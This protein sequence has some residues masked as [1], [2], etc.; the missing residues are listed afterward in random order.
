MSMTAR[1]RLAHHSREAGSRPVISYRTMLKAGRA[2]RWLVWITI[3]AS[4][5]LGATYEARTSY[6]QAHLLASFDKGVRFWTAPGA[7]PLIRFPRHGPRNRQLGYAELSTIIPSLETDRFEVVRQAQWSPRLDWFVSHGGYMPYSGKPQAGLRILD[8]SGVPLFN[9]RYP[10]RVYRDFSEIPAIVA[11]TLTSVEDRELLDAEHPLRDPAV[12][13]KRFAAAA[14]GRIAGLF[15]HRWQRGGASTL[16]TQIVKFDDSPEGR[17]E[18]ITEKLRQMLTAAV[19]AYTHGPGTL[20]V[21]E[22]ILLTYLNSTPLA[23]RPGYG[24]VIGIPEALW[25]WYGTDLEEADRVLTQPALSR[26]AI[27]RQGEI[28]RQI[29][30]LILAGQRPAYYLIQNH[31]ALAALVNAYLPALAKT[32]VISV[33]LRNAAMESKLQF[34]SDVPPSQVTFVENKATDFVQSELLS[35]LDLDNLSSLDHYDLTVS[36]SIDEPTQQQVTSVLTHL[37]DLSYDRSLGLVGKQM[38]GDGDPALVTWSFVLYERDNGA[39]HVRIHVDSLNEPF[40]INSGAKLQLGSTAKLRTLIT[41][42]DIIVG[43]HHKFASQPPGMLQHLGATAPDALTR[44][45][46]SYLAKTRDPSL[47]PMLEA[48]MQRT[49]SAAPVTLFT[50]G[51]NNSFDNFQPWENRLVPTVQFAFENSINCAFV[52]LMSDIRNYYISQIVGDD[53]QLLSD[54]RDLARIAY[55]R[56]F[57][58]QEGLVYLRKFYTEDHGQ[59]TSQVVDNLARHTKS[60]ASHLADVYLTVYPDADQAALT[61]FL[62]THLPAEAFSKLSEERLAELHNEFCAGKLSLIDA[63]YVADIH[64]L[65]FWLVRYLRA[66]PD[67]DWSEIVQAS[68]DAIQRSYAW[69]FR[70]DKT[71]QQ[72]LRIRTILEQKAFRLIWQ[73]WRRQGYPFDRLVPSLGTAIGASGDRPNALADLMGIIIN[74]GVRQPTVDLDRLDFADSTPY[75]TDFV[76]KPV[77]QRELNPLVAQT[78]RQALIGVVRNGTGAAVQGAYRLADGSVLPIGGKTGTGDNR[79]HVYGPGGHLRGERVVDRTATFVFFIGSRFF[80]TITAYVQGPRAAAFNF[81]SA[82]TVQLLR[83]LQPQLRPLLQAAP[84]EQNSAIYAAGMAQ[85]R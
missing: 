1:A 38:L 29:L 76:P 69:L 26:E 71:F 78:V 19:S 61:V 74:N 34:R 41:Y 73:D 7:N 28:Y 55:L 33:Q 42:L 64:P 24:A 77:P 65:A 81:S 82:L 25:V 22:A 20:A 66:H 59:T 54:P 15:D 36:S 83:T 18:S 6:L 35:L 5:G 50:G 32:G 46:A 12:E 72:N 58:E 16:A 62:H 56:R 48:A 80:G 30:S 39:N 14:F 17:T 37:D 21:R 43:L 75:Q 63:G 3:A 8:R 84:R 53:S 23:A 2:L 52:R 68:P 11:N 85:P 31:V 44:W 51:G 60:L 4:L 79:Y 47:E 9:A 40:D 45:A 10:Q 57:A 27:A 67:A 49:Y 70:P 13:W